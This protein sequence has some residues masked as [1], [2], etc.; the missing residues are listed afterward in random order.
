MQWL[1]S[2]LVKKIEENPNRD[3]VFI[4][5]WPSATQIVQMDIEQVVWKRPKKQYLELAEYKRLHGDPSQAGK[6]VVPG[7]NGQQL[8]CVSE[9]NVW[10][11]EENIIF[12]AV[13]QRTVD[14]GTDET[15]QQ[16]INDR[17]RQCVAKL[18]GAASSSGGAA[19]GG[20]G[21]QDA[22][23]APCVE[24]N[25]AP[26]TAA[27]S[28]MPAPPQPA[29]V[30]DAKPKKTAGKPNKCTTRSV[31]GSAAGSAGASQSTGKAA[32]KGRGRPKR[33]AATLLRS[34]LRELSMS[35]PGSKFFT[36]DWRNVNRNWAN[37][38]SD[39]AKMIEDETDEATLLDLQ[40]L[41]KQVSGLQMHHHRSFAPS[42][43]AHGT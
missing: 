34:G 6:V 32:I 18:G 14:D 23:A 33:D 15:A 42:D 37:Y 40:L 9:G 7:P 3:E 38:K 24:A 16:F 19:G 8:V 30:I 26:L 22:Q 1:I 20:G 13:K 21:P 43:D 36:G 39:L 25:L 31:A 11:K 41:E 28:T 27:P 35:D 29:A 12:Q 5:S 10:E 2:T 17:F 4:T